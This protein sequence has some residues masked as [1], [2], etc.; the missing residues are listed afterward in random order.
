MSLPPALRRTCRGNMGTRCAI[1][2][3]ELAIS[4]DPSSRD[5]GAISF[6]ELH[7]KCAS[8]I[9]TSDPD[10]LSIEVVAGGNAGAPEAAPEQAPARQPGEDRHLDDDLFEAE[11]EED[12]FGH[13][14]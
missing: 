13:A 9:Q 14:A 2:G 12:P 7:S 4:T 3:R 6:A 8:K 10:N 11:P 1:Q 5:D